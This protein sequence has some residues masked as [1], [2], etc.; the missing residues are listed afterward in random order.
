M[1][2][3]LNEKES[4]TMPE[5][6]RIVIVG[7]GIVGLAVAREAGLRWPDASITVLEKESRVATHQTGHNS[8][9]VHSGLY[10][11]P[12]SLK[13]QLCVSG[14]KL[15]R[16]YCAEKGLEIRDVGKVVV[17]VREDEEARLDTLF[18]RGT[19]NGVPGLRLISAAEL[20]EREPHAVGRRAIFSPHTA[21]VDYKAVCEALA[22][23]VAQRGEVVLGARVVGVRRAHGGGRT[24]LVDGPAGEAYPCDLLINC[25]GLAADRVA[26]MTGDNDEPRIV[27]FRGEYF[28]L[29]ARARGLVSGLIYPV[30]D[31]RY[32]FLG[33]HLTPTMAGD[34]LVGPNA[35]LAYEREGYARLR[36]NPRDLRDTLFWPGFWAMAKQH[37]RTGIAEMYRSFN[38]SRYVRTAQEYIPELTAQDLRRAPAGVRAQAV[39]RNGAL[40]DDFWISRSDGVVNV[41]NAPS[42]GATASLAIAGYVC[43]QIAHDD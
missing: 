16:Q 20:R 21:I 10:Y 40:V 8:G 17:A 42:P 22:G 27:P 19:T 18:E 2:S 11:A 1:E 29:G 15:L 4:R 3:G 35:V 25:A 32:P 28:S 26:M 30:P 38:K 6:Q 14:V 7:G 31:P 34:V 23:D 39:A 41:R 43:D 12:G 13:A 33:V 5:T 24:V 37:W 36:V 9:V